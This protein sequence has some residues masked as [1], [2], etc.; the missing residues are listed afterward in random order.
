[1]YSGGIEPATLQGTHPHPA[2]ER[3]V[4][5]LRRRPP[6]VLAAWTFIRVDLPPRRPFQGSL[7]A[8]PEALDPHASGIGAKGQ[9][10]EYFGWTFSPRIWAIALFAAI[11]ASP[12]PIVISVIL[13]G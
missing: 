3:L 5:R 11:A 12:M 9:S 7:L 8:T 2:A 4:E 6:D 10:V 1:V 13:P